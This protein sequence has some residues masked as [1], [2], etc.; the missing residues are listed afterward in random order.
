MWPHTLI[1]VPLFVHV[2]KRLGYMH[3]LRTLKT[4]P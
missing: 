4:E 2:C 1:F 3:W